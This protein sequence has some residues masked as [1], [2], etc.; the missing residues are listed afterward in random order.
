MKTI[1]LETCTK[2]L[3]R[4]G[5]AKIWITVVL[6]AIFGIS[7]LFRSE[8]TKT[9][10]AD[11]VLVFVGGQETQTLATAEKTVLENIV[12]NPIPSNYGLI[13]WNGSV[14]TVS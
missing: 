8:I 6:T 5:W 7:F 13:T 9:D 3:A 4:I 14:L 10:I 1:T 11:A 2:G 12:I